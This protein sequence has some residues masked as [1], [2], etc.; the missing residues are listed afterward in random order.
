[1]I[2]N[3][4]ESIIIEHAYFSDDQVIAGV[5]RA[6]QRDVKVKI[7]LPKKPDTH[8]YANMVTVN[9]L[10][11]AG[12]EKGISIYL[13]PKMSHAK[14]A[15][16][17]GKIAVIGSANLTPRSMRTSREVALFVH[18]KKDDKFIKKLHDQ[19]IAD[20]AESELV[21]NPFRIRITDKAK[22]LVGKYVW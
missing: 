12:T 11:E 3:A 6:A 10:L 13:F 22:A 15:L 16:A 18:G 9:R 14:V 17:D 4:A 2:D 8:H 19:L 5:K 21:F 20:M 1:M 7:I